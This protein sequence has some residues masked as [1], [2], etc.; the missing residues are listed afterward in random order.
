MPWQP[1]S[2]AAGR[3]GRG[4]WSVDQEMG[5][6]RCD[7]LRP[8]ILPGRGVNV[9]H[10]PTHLGDPAGGEGIHRPARAQVID[11]DG[12]GLGLGDGD[13]LGV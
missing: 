11:G 10:P 4:R 1:G 7:R 2:R 8:V 3:S 13:G 12:D 9:H 5:D 6:G